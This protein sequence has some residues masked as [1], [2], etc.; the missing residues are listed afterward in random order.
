MLGGPNPGLLWSLRPARGSTLTAGRLSET[1]PD[2][3]HPSDA[4]VTG[5]RWPPGSCSPLKGVLELTA[6]APL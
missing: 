3:E 5:P 6:R 2:T 4:E 1:A